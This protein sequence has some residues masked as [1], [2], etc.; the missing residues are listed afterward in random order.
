MDPK[1]GTKTTEFWTAV[2]GGLAAVIPS[3][4]SALSGR[5]WAA[6]ALAVAGVAL[7]AIYIWGRA[8]LKAELA[9]Q[10]QVIPDAWEPLLEKVLDVV[11]TVARS[12]PAA[13]SDE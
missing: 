6:A 8:V 4:L 11:E 2:L 3:V 9:R 13:T 10:T 12:L 7:P 1:P 5:P